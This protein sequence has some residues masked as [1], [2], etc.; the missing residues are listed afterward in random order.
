[1][2]HLP[3][4]FYSLCMLILAASADTTVYPTI[5]ENGQT[6]GEAAV[7]TRNKTEGVTRFQIFFKHSQGVSSTVLLVNR[8]ILGG[9]IL[10]PGEG[11]VRPMVLH[12]DLTKGL[13][14]PLVQHGR[15]LSVQHQCSLLL[16]WA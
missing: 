13:H 16:P 4:K 15:F 3:A 8:N 1:M 11:Q 14:L 7:S 5:H 6:E 10:I 9:V 2:A 12:S